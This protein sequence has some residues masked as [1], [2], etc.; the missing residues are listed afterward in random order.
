MKKAVVDLH[1]GVTYSKYTLVA[2]VSRNLN[3]SALLVDK[4]LSECVDGV[5]KLVETVSKYNDLLIDVVIPK[6]FHT[7]YKSQTHNRA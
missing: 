5:D 4:I 2:E 3:I 1:D 7:L 6:I